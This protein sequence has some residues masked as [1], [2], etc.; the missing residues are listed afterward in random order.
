[1]HDFTLLI[2]LVT[3]AEVEQILSVD[4]SWKGEISAV[5][6][7]EGVLVPSRESHVSADSECSG[8]SVGLVFCEVPTRMSPYCVSGL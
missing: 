3:S 7:E 5:L 8:G 2:G 1:M 4:M 6:G